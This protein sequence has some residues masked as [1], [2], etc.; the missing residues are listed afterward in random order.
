M[1]HEDEIRRLCTEVRALRLRVLTVVE[2]RMLAL[3]EL[4]ESLAERERLL[5]WSIEL[6]VRAVGMA[7]GCRH[8]R[9]TGQHQ[10]T[11]FQPGASVH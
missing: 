7:D 4:R 8:E 2:R 9:P 6:R 11:H 3:Y 1:E 10:K 5:M